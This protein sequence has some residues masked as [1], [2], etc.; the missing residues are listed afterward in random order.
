MSAVMPTMGM[1]TTIT[2]D[3]V[4]QGNH[5]NLMKISQTKKA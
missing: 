1:M 2:W 4:F 5:L 3:F